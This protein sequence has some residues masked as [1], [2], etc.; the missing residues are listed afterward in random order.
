ME[1]DARFNAKVTRD[2]LRDR[3]INENGFVRY[4]YRPLDVRWLYWETET[5]LLDERR[6]DLRPHIFPGNLGM[7]LA[8]RTRKGFEPPVVSAAVTSYHVIESVSLFFPLFLASGIS[9][10][11]KTSIVRETPDLFVEQVGG[12][13]GSSAPVPNLTP[14]ARDYLAEVGAKP[15]DLFFHIVAILHAPAYRTENAGALRQD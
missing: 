15:E 3:G 4:C 13:G 2:F 14:F 6:A 7:V 5:K 12:G 8:Q 11:P 1:D 9:N 10:E